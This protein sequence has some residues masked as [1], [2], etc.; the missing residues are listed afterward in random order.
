MCALRKSIVYSY[1]LRLPAWRK[2][3]KRNLLSNVAAS[4]SSMYI[5]VLFVRLLNMKE[6]TFVSIGGDNKLTRELAETLSFSMRAKIVL[7]KHIK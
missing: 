2:T 3:L 7:L 5:N 1:R 4:A 6:L